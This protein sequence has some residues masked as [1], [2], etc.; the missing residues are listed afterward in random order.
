MV[1]LLYTR[2]TRICQYY[3][4]CAPL[5]MRPDGSLHFLLRS[6]R[7]ALFRP[8]DCRAPR[9]EREIELTLLFACRTICCMK[10]D[11]REFIKK[12]LYAVLAVFGLG[13][14]APA[15][16][17]LAPRMRDKQLVYYPLLPEEEI[18]RSGVKKQELVYAVSG[19]E[20]K[21]RFFVVS[22]RDGILVLSATCTHLGCL[23]NYNRERAEFICPCHGGRYDLSGRNIAGP[24]PAPLASIPFRIEQGVLSVGI[25]V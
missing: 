5:V 23:V 8:A 3:F 19:T 12:A 11:R 24:P 21:A 22:G 13:F 17:L 20:R 7:A 10:H 25:K 6:P 9:C 1:E 14:L 4:S 15:A 16:V 2:E 18:P